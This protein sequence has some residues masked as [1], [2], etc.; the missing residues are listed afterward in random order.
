MDFAQ[1]ADRPDFLFIA[2][3]AILLVFVLIMIIVGVLTS[4][5][6]RQRFIREIFQNPAVQERIK[7][8]QFNLTEF[9]EGIVQRA[10]ERDA[11]LRVSSVF[12]KMIEDITWD[13]SGVI[14]VMVTIVLM[15]MIVSQK[16]QDIPKEVFAGCTT[17]LGFYFGRAAKK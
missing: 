2:I 15:V 4:G 16:F 10:S 7:D 17:I 9:I 13:V 6:A 1:F 12:H 5:N 11:A 8:P 14:G 3:I